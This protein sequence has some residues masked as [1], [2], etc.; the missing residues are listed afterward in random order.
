MTQASSQLTAACGSLLMVTDDY[1]STITDYEVAC[2]ARETGYDP[3]ADAAYPDLCPA[4]PRGYSENRAEFSRR[5]NYCLG[6]KTPQKC[7]VEYSLPLAIVVI[8]ANVIK[9]GILCWAAVVL[10]K[11][12]I[13][14]TGDAVASFTKRP[15]PNTRALCLLSRDLVLDPGREPWRFSDSP[16]RTRSAVSVPLW[17]A[18]LSLSVLPLFYIRVIYHLN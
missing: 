5:V 11:T 15:D 7:T 12:P 17:G 1:N 9:A 10:K 14:T 6:G 18:C 3:F 8:V 13:L 4:T 16:K 2:H